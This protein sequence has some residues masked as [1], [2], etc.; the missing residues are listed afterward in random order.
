M[1][2][3][4]PLPLVGE[5]RT[6]TLGGVFRTDYLTYNLK[7]YISTIA[8]NRQIEQHWR[9]SDSTLLDHSYLNIWYILTHSTR[10]HLQRFTESV[11]SNKAFSHALVLLDLSI[12][13]L[14]QKC[15]I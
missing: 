5:Q 15:G 7:F 8:D 3:I 9:I 2:T 12:T 4:R 14:G 13:A 11:L 10:S 6:A 1:L